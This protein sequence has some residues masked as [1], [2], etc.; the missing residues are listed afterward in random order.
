MISSESELGQ[1]SVIIMLSQE[2]MI[3]D[4]SLSLHLVNRKNQFSCHFHLS[5]VFTQLQVFLRCA[6]IHSKP[7]HSPIIPFC[8]A[9]FLSL[10]CLSQADALSSGA[11]M[12]TIRLE[13]LTSIIMNI[14]GINNGKHKHCPEACPHGFRALSHLLNNVHPYNPIA[15]H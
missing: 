8:S 10:C 6:D 2:K 7:Y 13:F 1:I 4:R 9:C 3:A 15:S 12:Q 11:D 5:C 14:S